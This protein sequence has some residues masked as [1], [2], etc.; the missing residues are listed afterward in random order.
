MA[1]DGNGSAKQKE[2]AEVAAAESAAAQIPPEELTPA[3]Q[4]ILA[5]MAATQQQL[6]EAIAAGQAPAPAP[7]R[8]SWAGMAKDDA[9]AELQGT[10]STG[11]EPEGEDLLEHEV[12][13][14]SSDKHHNVIRRSRHRVTLPNGEVRISEGVHFNFEPAGEFRTRSRAVA[15]YLRSRPGFNLVFWEVGAEPD[16]VPSPEGVLRRV[17]AAM[18]DLDVETLDSIEREERQGHKREIVLNSISGARE[19]LATK[20]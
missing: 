9:E 12:V 2:K 1:P 20:A 10:V 6:V 18:R 19:L 16:R 4:A 7:A 8:S 3:V 5:Q 17:M 11:P 15:D 13:F 14:R